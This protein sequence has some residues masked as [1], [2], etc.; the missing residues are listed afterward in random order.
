TLD[1]LESYELLRPF[2]SHNP[3]PMFMARNIKPASQPR[4]IKDKHLKFLFEQDG[5][6]RDAIFFNSAQMDIPNP[7]WDVAFH[8]DRNE[9]RGV[10]QLSIF[11]QA[12]RKAA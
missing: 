2:G 5:T 11:V 3:Q 4:L 9:Y 6:T 10:A 1:L 7:P 12:I 8:I